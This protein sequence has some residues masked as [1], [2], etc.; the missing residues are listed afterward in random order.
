MREEKKVLLGL[1]G[2][3]DS[4]AAAFL[5]QRQGYQVTGLFFDVLGNQERLILRAKTAAEQLGISFLYRNVKEEF[6]E[7]IIGDFC[8]SYLRGETPNPCVRCNP[9]L[10]FRVLKQEADRIGAYYLATGHYARV[11]TDENGIA[12]LYT[13]KNQRKDQSY[14]MYRLPQEIL[15]RLTLP[16]GETEEK[17]TVRNLLRGEG[18]S[19][20][21]A[22][23]SQEICF[24]PD[25]S[26]GDYLE[27]KGH[28]SPPGNFIDPEGNVLGEHQGISHYTIGQRKGLGITF[29]KPVFV[30]DID[31]RCNTVTLGDHSDLFQYRVTAEDCRF[32]EGEADGTMLPKQYEGM[33]VLAKI[34]YAAKPALAV[35]RQKENGRVE[36]VFEE[37]QRAP[38]PGQSMVFY[39]GDRCLGGGFIIRKEEQ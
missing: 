18:L 23:D 39:L 16:L 29:G 36:A 12:S 33:Q 10:K 11:Q 37:P 35:V 30:T 26:Y 7:Q 14:M 27:S 25:G 20:A 5:L 19:N 3:V 9:L 34:R 17:E 2:G 4:T 31:P 1:S 21:E 32:P 6:E 24:I 13:G 15:Q 22:K 8:S 28:S 38:T